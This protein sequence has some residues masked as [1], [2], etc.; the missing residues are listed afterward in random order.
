MIDYTFLERRFDQLYEN[1]LWIHA[2]Y[3]VDSLLNKNSIEFKRVNPSNEMVDDICLELW[4]MIDAPN[5]DI[6]F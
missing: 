5:E 4:R 3:M 2:E 6:P 1:D